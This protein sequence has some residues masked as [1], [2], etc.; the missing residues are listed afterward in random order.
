MKVYALDHIQLAIPPN[1]E[2]LAR[3]FYSDRLHQLDL[4]AIAKLVDRGYT[5]YE[6]RL[7]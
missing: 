5:N 3:A 4:L 2:D 7:L 6:C 1:S